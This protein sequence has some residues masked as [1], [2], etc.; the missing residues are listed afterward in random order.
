MAKEGRLA[1][2]LIELL[3]RKR[4]GTAS[5]NSDR[6]ALEFAHASQKLHN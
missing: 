6:Q 3:S 2:M 1:P 4:P 5:G